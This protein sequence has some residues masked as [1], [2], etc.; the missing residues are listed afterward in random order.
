[1]RVTG[2]LEMAERSVEALSGGELQR[3]WLASC[4]AQETR[5]LLLD[6]PTNHL[7]LRYQVDILEVMRALAD[8]ANVAVGVVLHDLAHAADLA[9]EVVLMCNGKVH[10]AGRP[11]DVITPANIHAVYGVEVHV[12]RDPE[13]GHM[14]VQ[15]VGRYRPTPGRAL[16]SA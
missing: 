5:V 8:S 10:A 9:D 14:H 16:Q 6:E 15:P 4:L 11:E 1:M 3:V 13:S 2:I 12:R 7:D